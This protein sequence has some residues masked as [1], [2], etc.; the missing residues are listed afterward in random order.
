MRS[1]TIYLFFIIFMIVSTSGEH[2]SNETNLFEGKNLLLFELSETRDYSIKIASSPILIDSDDDFLSYGFPG[3]G[4][5]TN[6]FLIQNLEIDTT[7]DAGIIIRDTTKN[8]AIQNCVITATFVGIYLVNNTG[9]ILD[10]NNNHCINTEVWGI[11]TYFCSNLNI[12]ENTCAYNQGGIGVF[13]SNDSVISNNLC[14]DN[15]CGIMGGALDR[16]T[17]T[18][19]MCLYNLIDGMNFA[20]SKQLTLYDNLCTNSRYG[21]NLYAIADSI[22]IENTVQ[23]ADDGF[24]F[25]GLYNVSMY[26]NDLRLNYVG[27]STANSNN[28]YIGYNNCSDGTYGMWLSEN[29][30]SIIEQNNCNRNIENGMRFSRSGSCLI[31]DNECNDNLNNGMYVV[32][33]D[34]PDREDNQIINNTCN[35][36][37][38]GINL[39]VSSSFFIF[40]NTCNENRYGIKLED[41]SNNEIIANTFQ[42]NREYGVCITDF[43]SNWNKVYGNYF[44]CNNLAGTEYGY[45]Q[46][47]DRNYNNRWYD[48]DS[49]QGNFW[50]DFEGEGEYV[51]DGNYNMTDPYPFIYNYDCQATSKPT[52]EQTE[53][54]YFGLFIVLLS[55]LGTVTL[56]KTRYK[57]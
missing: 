29:Y 35:N 36:N 54:S 34:R 17:I 57:K 5:E 50:T 46:A 18:E 55:F 33:H 16:F 14:Y 32:S 22:L 1:R 15:K 49:D 48:Y 42:E 38:N 37:T 25:Y 11:Y 9:Q 45:S 7:S 27:I 30:F 43:E 12:S 4:S 31:Q 13:I 53:E 47:Y 39:Y 8:F 41:S 2:K 28:L 44:I 51:I 23:F 56:V 10:I 19:N 26:R 21:I 24:Y 52:T 20:Y 3:N 6:P 40:N